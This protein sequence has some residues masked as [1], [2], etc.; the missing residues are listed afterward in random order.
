MKHISNS[1]ALR[2]AHRG[3]APSDLTEVESTT[4]TMGLRFGRCGHALSAM[5][6]QESL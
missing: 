3:A 2:A 1:H 4:H 5:E 6:V